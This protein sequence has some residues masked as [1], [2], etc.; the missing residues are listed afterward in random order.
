[1]YYYTITLSFLSWIINQPFYTRIS[2]DFLINLIPR[3][4][5]VRLLSDSLCVFV[6]CGSL[7]RYVVW[8][9]DSLS[10]CV[11]LVAGQLSGAA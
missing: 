10:P 4:T 5:R 2:A 6:A 7:S 9:Y 1:M 11:F 8:V 3:D